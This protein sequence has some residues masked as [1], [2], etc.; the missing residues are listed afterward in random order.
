M[1]ANKNRSER[2]PYFWARAG[3]IS[4]QQGLDLA[5]LKRAFLPVFERLKH[6]GFFQEAFGY[7][8]SHARVPGK[9]G[10]VWLHLE[11]RLHKKDLW[12]I[13]THLDDYAE[14]DLFDIIEVL[15]DHTS[16]GTGGVIQ[17]LYG[18]GTRYGI[19]DRNAG[20]REFR[21]ALNDIL[22]DYDRGYELTVAGEIRVMPDA[23]MVSL[24]AE[25]MTH[26]DKAN[27]V[28]RVE[29]A[30][31]KFLRRGASVDDHRDAVRE[32]ASVLEFVRPQAKEVLNTKDEADLFRLANEFG[33]RHHNQHQKTNYD[34]AIW[35]SWMFYHFLASIHACVRLLERPRA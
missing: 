29:A 3:K 16:K 11:R 4:T 31:Q 6:D 28:K 32:L 10:E 24:L 17:S 9:L 26:P 34:E 27:V 20:R 21:T 19:F 25:P 13:P 5:G 33:I 7:E 8:G 12:P 23:G 18:G 14:D 22:A 35:L 1:A 30:K 2:R 15:Y